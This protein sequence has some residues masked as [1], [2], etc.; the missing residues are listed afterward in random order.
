MVEVEEIDRIV[1][2]RL[3][4][5]NLCYQCAKCSGICPLSPISAFRPRKLVIE[6]QLRP[7]TVYQSETLWQ[8][9]TC[10]ACVTRCPEGVDIP[11]I[12]ASLRSKMIE[13]GR[14]PQEI[15]DTLENIYKRNNPWGS[16]KSERAAWAKDLNIK[17]V[18]EGADLLYFVGCVPAYDPRSRKIAEAMVNVFNQAGVNFGILG[19]DERCCGDSARRLG[20]EGLFQLLAE[21]NA[22]TFNEHHVETIVTTSP[23][24]YNVFKNEY[25]DFKGEVSHYTQFLAKLLE[26]GKLKFTPSNA[27]RVTVTYQDPCYLGRYNKVYD[28]P[29][30]VLESIPGIE[31]VEMERSGEDS[32]CCGGGGGRM[33]IE[34]GLEEERLSEIRLKQ[35]LNTG[36]KILVTACPFCLLNFEEAVKILDVED[37]I[38][39]KDLME[40]VCTNLKIREQE[41]DGG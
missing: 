11:E 39:I 23:H 37:Q 36:A 21:E 28:P 31:L 34:S 20:E 15:A 24:C 17:H 5:L 29:R 27:E 7:E 6:S 26:E 33:W 40:L 22:Q 30:T 2:S 12:V 18:S 10:R 25:P 38:E 16:P 32:I 19:N 35:A 8:C 14:I 3:A 13:D 9:T 1:E 41:G 4:S